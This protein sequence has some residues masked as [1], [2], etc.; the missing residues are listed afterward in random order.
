MS[1][2]CFVVTVGVAAYLFMP[3]VLMEI[4]MDRG[5]FAIG[6]E[7]F[8]PLLAMI[9]S[10]ILYSINWKDVIWITVAFV[11]LAIVKTLLFLRFAI[12]RIERVFSN[13]SY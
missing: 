5:Y 13:E 6:G 11:Y 4:Y 2:S 7:W 12:K 8:I 3:I 1:K 10:Y 9:L